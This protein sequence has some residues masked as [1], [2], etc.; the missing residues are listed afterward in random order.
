LRQHVVIRR[1]APGPLGHAEGGEGR[2]RRRSGR[3]SKKSL[4][5][6]FAPGPAALDIIDKPLFPSPSSASAIAW[7]YV[8]FRQS[9]TENCTPW[10]C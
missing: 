3:A 10:V 5:V 1:R 2:R 4:S 8:I 9:P 7:F 6:G